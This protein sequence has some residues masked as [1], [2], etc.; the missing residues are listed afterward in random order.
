MP[1]GKAPAAAPDGVDV[2]WDTSGHAHL[3]AAAEMVKP[4]GRILVTAGPEAQPPTPLR[5]LYTQDIRV[6]GFVI[7]R[8][9]VAE[10]A[11]AA[12]GLNARLGGAG[13]AINVTDVLALDMTGEAH[14]AV[15]SG[16]RGRIV[17]RVTPP[18]NR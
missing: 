10:L 12:R 6:I 17:I 3:S 18:E 1:A 2:H 13:F 9:T 4:G 15:E 16:H 11:D 14:A 7:S 8:A 5:P